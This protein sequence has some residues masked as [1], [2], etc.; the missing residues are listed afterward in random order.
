ML[1][2]LEFLIALAREKHFG[3]AA[4]ACGVAQPTLSIG[5]QNLEEMFKVPLVK[6]SSRF[7]G[8][9]PEGERVLLWAQRLVGDAQAMREEILSLQTGGGAHIRIASIPFAMLIVSRLTMPF[10]ERHPRARFTVLARTSD[11]VVDLLHQREVDAGITYLDNDPV[12]EVI[13]LPLYRDKFMLLTRGDGALG[14]RKGV[15]WPDIAPLPLC[16]FT[17]DMQLRR[18]IDNVLRGQKLELVPQIETDSASALV[19]HV[20][21]GRWV[22]VVPLSMIQSLQPPEDLRAIPVVEPEVAHT[23]GLVVSERFA[24]QPAIV[25]LMEEARALCPPELAGAVAPA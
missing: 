24:I 7:K 10:Q 15:S 2:R 19:S 14:Q 17:R 22:S 4:A 9:T 21:T 11:M 8:F 13:K 23:I 25:S 12:G 3:R 5:I 16:L 20:R 18:M 6:R 1:D